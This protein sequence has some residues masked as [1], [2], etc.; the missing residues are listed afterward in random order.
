MLD[1]PEPRD[2]QDQT[3]FRVTPAV[4]PPSAPAP[5]SP[6]RRTLAPAWS[7]RYHA[8]ALLAVLAAGGYFATPLLFG[9]RILVDP[10]IRADYL[11]TVVAT[12]HVE[13]PNRINI[14]S[15]IVGIVAEVPVIEGQTVNAGD[16]LVRLD[17]HE[18][19]ADV[20]A[21]EGAVAQAAARLRQIRELT[22]PSAQ[23]GL[24][25][26]QA[27]LFDAQREYERAVT[28]AR[29][30]YGTIQALDEATKTLDVPASA[31]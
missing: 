28:L 3:L 31:G 23:E 14:G 10:V 6:R 17:D 18:A 7:W 13:A 19:R 27:T 1:Q 20:I 29:D 16:V 11:Q 8:L 24:K 21:A 5:P 4:L 15:Q 9:P 12:G 22:L 2:R 25:Q 30:A 26:A